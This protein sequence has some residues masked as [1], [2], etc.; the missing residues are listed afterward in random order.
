MELRKSGTLRELLRRQEMT[1]RDVF[2]LAGKEYDIDQ[3]TAE[4]VEIETKYEGYIK[5]QLEEVQC[6]KKIEEIRIPAIN[7]SEV[8]GLSTEIREKLDK[9]R[10]ASIGQASRISGVTPAAISMLMVHL[11]KTGAYK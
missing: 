4:A 3:E 7:F 9:V 8:Q 11:K 2:A 6:F 10:P 1:L 5:R